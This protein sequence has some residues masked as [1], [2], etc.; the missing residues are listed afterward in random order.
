MDRK[1]YNQRP[2]VL[3]S[4]PIQRAV[5][6]KIS[7]HCEVRVHPLDEAMP[8]ELLAQAIR[9]VD[10]LM[11][12]GQRV[13]KDTLEAAA[14]LRVIANVAVGYDNI[15]VE[16]CTRRGILVTNTPDVLT[17]ATA[18]V[19]FALIMAAARRVVEGDRYVREGCWSHWQWN[20][21]WGADLHRKTLGLYGFGRIAQAVARRGRGFSMRILY[22]AR[23]RADERIEKELA[24]EF[25]D[26][27]ALLRESDFLS[28]HVPLTAETRHTVTG[29]RLAL[30]KPTAYLINTARG[31]VVDE[32]ALVQALQAGTIAGAGL[33]VFENE[34]QVSPALLTMQNVTLL[35]HIGSATGETRLR[36]ATL[37]TENLLAALRG[38]TPPNLV[39]P[40]AL[41]SRSGSANHSSVG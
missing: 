25:V 9:D 38:E 35:P 2:R 20:A 40:Q 30:M 12:V 18:D 33:D 26:A 36:M 11:C 23:H 16:T 1:S 24:A 17:E 37:A 14:E 28:L 31:P 29:S 6:D 13:G 3:I 41:P 39:N 5:I 32:A 21:M 22:H 19:A 8:A 34:P 15:D 7:Q 4:R 10:G 27:E